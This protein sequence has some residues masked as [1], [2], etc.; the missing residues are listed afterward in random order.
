[1]RPVEAATVVTDQHAGVADA[2]ADRPEQRALLV[3][4]AEEILDERQSIPVAP[5]ETDQK[6]DGAGTAREP[7]GLGVEEERALHVFRGKPEAGRQ[8]LDVAVTVI[9]KP[10]APDR[11]RSKR[12]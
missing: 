8:G 1:Q 10:F 3:E 9:R 2:L 11:D 6:C 4:V 12:R 5:G 7:G